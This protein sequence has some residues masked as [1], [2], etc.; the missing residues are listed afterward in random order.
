MS[1]KTMPTAGQFLLMN[2][3]LDVLVS[4]SAR[5]DTPDEWRGDTE[6]YFDVKRSLTYRSRWTL[7]T[8][9]AA[10]KRQTRETVQYLKD[11]RQ[12][13][14]E[15]LAKIEGA[16]PDKDHV[17]AISSNAYEPRKSREDTK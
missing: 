3:A 16:E 12:Q 6:Y 11:L 10:L 14:D 9:E 13:I 5:P 1:K 4:V 17:I 15:V 8:H 2:A 7:K